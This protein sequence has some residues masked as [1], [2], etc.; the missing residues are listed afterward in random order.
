MTAVLLVEDDPDSREALEALLE[1][2]GRLVRSASNGREAIEQLEKGMRPAVILLDLMMPVMNGW[3][4]L[5]HRAR[6]PEWAAI[7]VVVLS[8]AAIDGKLAALGVPHLRKPID[9][10]ALER[11][12]AGY[13]GG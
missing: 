1:M 9:P 5:E 3:E 13:D 11:M 7:P 4:F 8:A 10:D 6:R 12:L 2:S